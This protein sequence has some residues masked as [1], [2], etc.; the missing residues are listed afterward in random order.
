MIKNFQFK[1][2]LFSISLILTFAHCAKS[3]TDNSANPAPVNNYTTCDAGKIKNARGDCESCPSG[4]VVSN[5]TCITPTTV[6]DAPTGLTATVVY[7]NLQLN[8]AQTNGATEFLLYWSTSSANF[9]IASAS[10]LK[11]SSY[12]IVHQSLLTGITYYY[13][14]YAKNSIGTST[15]FA[16]TSG[17][18][19]KTML[20]TCGNTIG[21]NGP[22]VV[23]YKWITTGA[24]PDLTYSDENVVLPNS[25]ILATFVKGC[26]GGAAGSVQQEL[27][28]VRSASSVL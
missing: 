10:L 19:Y 8:W 22:S 13:K 6:P 27:T 3:T 17:I 15:N 5:N 21:I 23:I 12:T 4:Q 18:P 2:I 20:T 28:N 9:N 11:T 25:R 7:D 26:D 16:S 14:L 24:G 1:Y